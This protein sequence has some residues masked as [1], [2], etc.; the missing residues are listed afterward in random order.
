MQNLIFTQLSIPEVRQLFREEIENFFK[1]NPIPSETESDEI[2]GIDLA[3]EITGLAKPTLYSLCSKRR[4]PH[5]KQGKRLYFNRAE[6]IR[7]LKDGKRKTQ[8]EIAAEAE[9]H[10]N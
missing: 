2:G 5:S 6:L 7:W 4:I 1:T 9:N 8:A 3:V 10:A